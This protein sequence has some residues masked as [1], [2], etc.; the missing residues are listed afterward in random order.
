M[1]VHLLIIKAQIAAA[2]PVSHALE[3]TG[4]FTVVPLAES[5]IALDYL[6][7][8][9][10][11]VVIADMHMPDYPAV[12]L[13]Q[14]VSAIQPQAIII[15]STSDSQAATEAI[16][17]GATGL[18]GGHYSAREVLNLLKQVE[19][20]NFGKP[21][22]PQSSPSN[23][24]AKEMDE[25]TEMGEG[26]ISAILAAEEPPL[27]TALEGGTVTTFMAQIS[28]DALDATLEALSDTF[29]VNDELQLFPDDDE[30]EDEDDTQ[31]TPAQLI[32]EDAMDE[33]MPL[34][35]KAFDVYLS[36]LQHE[37]AGQ[38][39]DEP[40]FLSGTDFSESV[41]ESTRPSG[42]ELERLLSAE[43]SPIETTTL[44]HDRA[45][46]VAEDEE[47]S[48][49]VNP[50]ESEDTKRIEEPPFEEDDTPA[51][52]EIIP[53]V[54]TPL[55]TKP[56]DTDVIRSTPALVGADS[57][58]FPT[59]TLNEGLSNPHI[60]QM[61][62]SLT[63]ASLES[64]AEATMLTAYGELVAYEGTLSDAD[65]TEFMQIIS[66]NVAAIEEH[67]A[68]IR[69]L[70]LSSNGL[71][72]MIYSR[73]TGDDYIL[74]MIF[75]GNTP[76]TDIRRQ[77]KRLVEA[78]QA[79]SQMTPED[80]I[81]ARSQD[82][83]A[84]EATDPSARGGLR[85][86]SK[87]AVPFDYGPLTKH[88]MMWLVEDPNLPLKYATAEALNAALRVQLI[89][90]GWQ[91]E[92]VDVADEYVYLIAGVPGETPPQQIIRDLQAR[93]TKIIKTVEPQR[94]SDR[95]WSD[96]YFILT[97]GRELAVQEIQQYISFYRM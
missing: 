29:P 45:P 91:L 74:S 31:E 34:D 40:D 37:T 90:N 36:Q 63:Q 57:T 71:E 3:Q 59:D 51:A 76:L 18:L 50:I 12:E 24:E 56:E 46:L 58:D 33:S 67:K 73:R 43:S 86:E 77:G 89:E 60:A 7:G 17:A 30:L 49:T 15:A 53:N 88:T 8:H 75:G 55:L 14:A 65:I 27:P 1:T 47:S 94:D 93:A 20:L 80:L 96:S 35:A 9:V 25:T 85:L 6:R 82:E 28:G 32:L 84:L 21:S 72:Y 81:E 79:V 95:L 16:Q 68:R 10:V 38:P 66:E 4:D 5:G 22:Q 26:N 61:A 70:T 39:Y 19:Y 92:R 97:P 44:Q 23:V 62:V 87:S 11:D 42:T 78:L 48:I 41:G 52:S 2:V 83:M 54:A 69:Y 64:T 13:L